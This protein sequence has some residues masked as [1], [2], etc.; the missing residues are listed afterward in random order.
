MSA[1]VVNL[2]RHRRAR[3]NTSRTPAQPPSV[4]VVHY[5]RAAIHEGVQIT[6]LVSALNGAGLTLSNLPGHGLVI[7]RMGQA[8]DRPDSGPLGVS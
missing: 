5:E 4:E 1:K 8:A 7:H 6:L 2:W 3:M